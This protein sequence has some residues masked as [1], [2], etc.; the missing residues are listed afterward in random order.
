[1]GGRFR[2]A[3]ATRPSASCT[4]AIHGK[5]A[6]CYFAVYVSLSAIAT[7]ASARHGWPVKIWHRPF[8]MNLGEWQLPITTNAYS[9]PFTRHSACSEAAVQRSRSAAH[10]GAHRT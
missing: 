8:L 3:E 2:P 6:A 9:R 5:A 10:V 7:V 4:T 1:M